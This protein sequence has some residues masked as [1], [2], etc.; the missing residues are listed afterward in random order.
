MELCAE[1]RRGGGRAMNY[2]E[3][4]N[5]L[6]S[7]DESMVKS[8]HQIIDDYS[9]SEWL[10]IEGLRKA[11]FKA[12]HPN[13]GWVDRKNNVV[14]LV[15]PQFND[16]AD[17]GDLVM[18]GWHNNPQRCRPVRLIGKRNSMFCNSVVYWSFEDVEIQP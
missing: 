4:K 6:R 12:A 10:W 13:D 14:Q 2:E 11:G 17:I 15:Y 5:S 9:F 1:Q 18:L 8:W 3:M 7:S 16:G